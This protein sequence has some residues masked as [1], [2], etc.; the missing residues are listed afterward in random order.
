M[1]RNSINQ[2]NS[3][4]QGDHD[5]IKRQSKKYKNEKY[6]MEKVKSVGKGPKQDLGMETKIRAPPQWSHQFLL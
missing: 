2:E 5:D 6:N 3:V 1:P 4:N